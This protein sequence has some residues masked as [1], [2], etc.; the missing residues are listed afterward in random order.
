MG[1]FISLVLATTPHQADAVERVV[2]E[3]S[4]ETPGEAV[5][6]AQRNAVQKELGA[7]ISSETMVENMTLIRDRILTRVKGYVKDYE[8]LSRECN[9][10]CRA[11]IKARVEKMTLA[12]DVAILCDILPRLNYPTLVA[13][14]EQKTVGKDNNLFTSGLT[15]VEETITRILID[16]G[17]RVTDFAAL[18]AKHQREAKLMSATG[19]NLGRA[20]EAASA[21][22]Q[23]MINCQALAEDN[24]PSPDKGGM[25]SY[26]A[27]LT[28]EVY[29][30]STGRILA[31]AMAEADVFHHSFSHG[32]Q[33]AMAKAAERLSGELSEKIIQSWLDACYNPHDVTVTI[34]K[35]SFSALKKIQTALEDINGVQRVNQ[36]DYLRGRA[37][38]VVGWLTCNTMRLAEHL[39][40]LKVEDNLLQVLE[41]EGNSIRLGHDG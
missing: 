40:Q 30:T 28:V 27:T 22:A 20:L 41:V 33:E 25:H 29:E 32:T 34:E 17:F 23:I 9:D 21:I 3:G 31:S 24:G 38:L 10:I 19:N 39:D 18:S 4:G 6:D 8:I 5:H 26:G 11:T 16:K 2:A 15:T 12:D 36:R 1:T 37:E 13:R 7:M 35:I 14:V